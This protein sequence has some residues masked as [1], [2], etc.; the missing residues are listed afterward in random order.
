MS[1]R[2]AVIL[3]VRLDSS[4]LPGKALLPL[5]GRTVIEHAMKALLE[6]PADV[7]ILATDGEG[8][9]QL[10]PFARNCG[11]ELF[12]G[13]KDD[14]L[15]RFVLAAAAYGAERVVRATGDNPLV[16][17]AL[18]AQLLRR[19]EEEGWDYGGFIG[20]P[21]GTGVE[22]VRAEALAE[23]GRLAEDPYERE[24]VTPYLYRRPERF[25]L[26]FLQAPP[27]SCAPEMRV[28]LDTREDYDYLQRL[29]ES[30]YKGVPVPVEDLVSYNSI[31]AGNKGV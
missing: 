31:A 23:A 17:G 13:P 27:E 14:V 11:F 16:S 3:Q 5:S 24:H 19:Q 1:C 18:A 20:P 21:V 15:G 12:E 29:F 22:V 2:D 8:A 26:A 25:R 28:T 9:P 10:L 30:C 6:V 4:R 7:H